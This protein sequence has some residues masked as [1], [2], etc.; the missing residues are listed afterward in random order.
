LTGADTWSDL[1]ASERLLIEPLLGSH[2]ELLFEAM[3]EP[4]LYRWISALPPPSRELL[5]QRWA[6]AEGRAAN[7][8]GEVDL[9]WAVR[10]LSDGCYVGKLDAAVARNS[11]ATNVGYIL[12]FPFWNQG[13]ATE[14]V[15]ALA[16]HLERQGVVEQRALV[17]LGNDA[18]ARVLTKAGFV[19]TR[20]IP[21]NDT[22][23]GEKYDDVEF[24]RRAS[25]GR[26][27][28]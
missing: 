23:R 13:Y 10:R 28:S 25:W 8:E 24:V 1:I 2:A 11:V 6:A 20:V 21:D 17:T 14:A 9:N 18:S 19:R 22:I 7:A 12:F 15:R 16:A 4:R 27:G 26:S 3:S 5:Q